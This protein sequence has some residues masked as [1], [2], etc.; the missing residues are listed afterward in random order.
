ML[1]DVGFCALGGFRGFD[2]FAEFCGFCDVVDYM[3]AFGGL[4][5]CRLC[6]WFCC[7]GLLWFELRLGLFIWWFSV[8]CWDG[9]GTLLLRF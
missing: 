3:V 5:C 2:G 7:A 8:L 4:V 6:W 1:W 9:W